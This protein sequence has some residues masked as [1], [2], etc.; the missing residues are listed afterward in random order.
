MAY[1]YPIH[2]EDQ[3]EV[4]QVVAVLREKRE[5]LGITKSRMGLIIC[6]NDDY[7]KRLE[8]GF[9]GNSR[10]S[11]YQKWAAGLGFRLELGLENFWL[12]SWPAASEMCALYAMSRPLDADDMARLWLVEAMRVWRLRHG[13]GD[14]QMANVLHVTQGAV[15]TWEKDA[16]DPGIRRTFVHAR[17]AGTRV[18]WTL[19]KREDWIFQ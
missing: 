8:T 7:V 4:D 15:Q 13:V 10:V 2:A 11:L 1:S 17:A 5:Q 14:I 9:Y 16:H 19:W 12:H 6:G 18:T 3:R